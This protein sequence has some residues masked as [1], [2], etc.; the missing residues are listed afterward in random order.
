M[1]YLGALAAWCGCP[2]PVVDALAV[3]DFIAL[4]T[5]IDRKRAA[6]EQGKDL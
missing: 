5:W 4:V 1:A 3:T 6:R 2:P